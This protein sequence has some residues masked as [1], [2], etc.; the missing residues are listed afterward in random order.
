MKKNMVLKT[1]FALISITCL[2]YSMILNVETVTLYE[3][4]FNM[5][6]ISVGI[7]ILLA[8]DTE[9][10]INFSRNKIKLNLLITGIYTYFLNYYFVNNF[11]GTEK[12]LTYFWLFKVVLIISCIY[13]YIG[14]FSYRYNKIKEY[15]NIKLLKNN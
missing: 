3:E 8:I 1:V 13:I 7:F 5:I 9:N 11:Y 6:I 4:Y 12:M 14:V 10:I 2:A 15:I